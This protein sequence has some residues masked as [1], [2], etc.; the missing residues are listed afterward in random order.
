MSVSVVRDANVISIEC[1]LKNVNFLLFY[2]L[3]QLNPASLSLTN[4]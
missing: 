2:S 1:F 4:F 3:V